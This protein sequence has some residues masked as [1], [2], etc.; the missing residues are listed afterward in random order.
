MAVVEIHPE[1]Q[2]EVKSLPERERKAIS[3]AVDK[4]RE[5]G[6][7]LGYPHSSQ[8]QG[9]SLRELR[10]RRGNSPWRAFYQRRG[11]QFFIV[12]AIGPEAIRDPRR[13]RRAVADAQDRL[14]DLE[15]L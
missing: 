4:L 8:V 13:F 5:L 1:A 6:D 3:N 11:D 7:A 2:T 9:T 15:V 14:A 10:P 12:A